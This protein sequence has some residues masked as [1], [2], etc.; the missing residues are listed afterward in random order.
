MQAHGTPRDRTAAGAAR[1]RRRVR[2]ALLVCGLVCGVLVAEVWMAAIDQPRIHVPPQKDPQI[3]M[4]EAPRLARRIGWVNQPDAELRILYDSDPRGYFGADNTVVHHT[5]SFGFRGPEFTRDKEP[6]TRRIAFLGDSITFGEGVTEEDVFARAVCRELTARE[7]GR[8]ECQNWGVSGYNSE[9]E[10][11]L[12]RLWV[13]DFDPDVVVLSYAFNDPQ[14]RMWRRNRAGTID[15]RPVQPG[16]SFAPFDLESRPW[17][18]PRLI[19]AAC[20]LLYMRI[21]TDETVE[22]FRSIHAPGSLPWRVTEGALARMGETC[23]E[24][25]LRCHAVVF[26]MLWD[27]DAYPLHE[28]H[29]RVVA[30]LEREDFAVLDLLPAFREHGADALWVHPL[31]QHP[32]EKAHALVTRLLAERLAPSDG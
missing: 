26:P 19:R 28:E 20:F 11:G 29:A 8:F 1:V 18:K 25:D 30:T 21:R 6:G 3:F 12:L 22:Y 27:L 17:C 5:N 15:Q 7:A 31:D 9:Q 4:L 23:R 2:I 13:L 16:E 14:P 32:N 10:A 24:R